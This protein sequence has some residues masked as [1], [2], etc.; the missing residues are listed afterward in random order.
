MLSTSMLLS[1]VV[2]VVVVAKGFPISYLSPSQHKDSALV[3]SLR[4]FLREFRKDH[5]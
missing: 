5:W 1:V 4:R 3:L 2:V